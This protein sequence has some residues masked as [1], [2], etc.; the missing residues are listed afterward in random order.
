MLRTG[1]G[2]LVQQ[3]VLDHQIV[4]ELR[5]D[6]VQ[7]HCDDRNSQQDPDKPHTRNSQPVPF[8]PPPGLLRQAALTHA[9]LPLLS[10]LHGASSS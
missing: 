7:D 8:E 9:D 6:Q 4:V 3:V 2:Q 1:L 10:L 5:V